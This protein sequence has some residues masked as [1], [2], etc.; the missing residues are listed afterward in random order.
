[1]SYVVEFSDE[2]ERERRWVD[3]FRDFHP[4]NFVLCYVCTNLMLVL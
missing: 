2:S 4:I 3:H 1:M